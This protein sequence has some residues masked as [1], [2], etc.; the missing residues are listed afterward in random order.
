MPTLGNTQHFFTRAGIFS[1]IA[2]CF[3]IPLSTSLAALTTGLVCL[4]WILSGKFLTLPRILASHPV[5]L[6]ATILFLLFAAGVFYSPTGLGDGLDT[7][8][9]YREL[10]YFPIIISFLDQDNQAAQW[11]E[12][13]FV[14]GCLVLLI[15]SCAMSFSII[16]PHKYGNSLIHHITHS[17]FMAI[18][19]FWAIHR[20]MDAGRSRVLWIILF[21]VTILNLVLIAPGRTGMLVFLLLISLFIMQRLTLKKQL[22]AFLV[23]LALACLSYLFSENISTRVND[24]VSE[25]QTFEQGKSRSS[26]GNRFNWYY[27]SLDLMQAKPI[28]GHGTGSFAHEQEE[29]IKGTKIKRTSNPHNEFLFIGV[30]LGWL[31]L[32]LFLLLLSLQWLNSLTLQPPR[33]WMLQGVI[34]SMISGCLMNSFLYDSL[35]GHYFVFLSSVFLATSHNHTKDMEISEKQEDVDKTNR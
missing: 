18:L 20:A 24:A 33:R 19:A 12:E 11:A 8:K 23:L 27:N 9:K 13:A 28:T 17:Y 22:S 4:F 2:A 21:L 25:I 5:A 16:P 6:V 32:L 7:L 30:Q 3:S 10:L 34:L 15:V 31:G 1:V 14:A 35:E 26:L 29:L